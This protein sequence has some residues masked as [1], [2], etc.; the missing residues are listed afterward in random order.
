MNPA[1]TTG[2][3]RS[4]YSELCA[5]SPEIGVKDGR[6][7]IKTTKDSKV[8]EEQMKNFRDNSLTCRSKITK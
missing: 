5:E 4:L 1:V 6:V 7:Y 8:T 2:V 3:R